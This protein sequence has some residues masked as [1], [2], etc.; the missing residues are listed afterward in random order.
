MIMRNAARAIM[1]VRSRYQE[2]EAV[3]LGA[4]AWKDFERELADLYSRHPE[5]QPALGVVRFMDVPVLKAGASAPN[6]LVEVH[7]RVGGQALIHV[8][9]A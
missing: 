4:E 9:M 3:L 8:V 1:C 5:Q 2:P 7:Y 6:Y